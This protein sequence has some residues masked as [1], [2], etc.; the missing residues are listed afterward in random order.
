MKTIY[1]G[2]TIE[3]GGR[4]F[5]VNIEQD[6]LRR[7]PWEDEDGHGIVS[8]WESRNKRPGELVLCEDGRS[9]RFYDI[10]ASIEIAKRDGWGLCPEELEAFTL[11]LKRT[12]TKAEITAHAAH[13]DYYN[14]RAWCNDEWRYVGVIVTDISED[15]DAETD[16]SNALWGIE[17]NA[18][19][20]LETVAHELIDEYNRVADEREKQEAARQYEE[21]VKQEARERQ[22]R[23]NDQLAAIGAYFL[24]NY[25]SELH[26]GTMAE[27]V[28]E[29]DELQKGV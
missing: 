15:E 19:E 29:L 6:E 13:L 1:D 17:S 21:A 5:R 3:R 20:Y 7:A 9:K 14:L 8:D 12:P 4:T 28:A 22:A 23:I 26:D 18:G 24:R 27:L 16:Y 10:P 25:D 11:K 2:Q